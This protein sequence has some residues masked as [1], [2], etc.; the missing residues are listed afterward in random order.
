M[1]TLRNMIEYST[2]YKTRL[3]NEKK[4]LLSSNMFK[5]E[6]FSKLSIP[7]QLTE[8]CSF[9]DSKGLCFCFVCFYLFYLV[10]LVHALPSQPINLAENTI[11]KKIRP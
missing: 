9:V 8:L 6:S 1:K 3:D 10:I 11:L 5:N 2:V 4:C 7:T